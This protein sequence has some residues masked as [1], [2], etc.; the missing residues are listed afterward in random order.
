MSGLLSLN[1]WKLIINHEQVEHTTHNI[2]QSICRNNNNKIKT[3]WFINLMDNEITICKYTL[4]ETKKK[5]AKCELKSSLNAKSW[6]GNIGDILILYTC[7]KKIKINRKIIWH[8]HQFMCQSIVL[9]YY[10]SILALW[11]EFLSI[12]IYTCICWTLISSANQTFHFWSQWK[13]N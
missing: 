10:S 4:R 11:W 1:N 2:I 3:Y 6:Y 8:Q 13:L 5:L 12:H 7:G 9:L